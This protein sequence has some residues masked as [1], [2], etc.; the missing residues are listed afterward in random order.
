MA[1]SEYIQKKMNSRV[2]DFQ[3]ESGDEII[4]YQIHCFSV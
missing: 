1:E 3:T 4:D 2:R